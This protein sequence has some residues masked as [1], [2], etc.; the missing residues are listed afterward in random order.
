SITYQYDADGNRIAVTDNHVTTNYAPNNLDQYTAVGGNTYRYDADGN[1]T[2]TSG[3]GGNTAYTYDVENRLIGIATATDTWSYQYD[4]L[5]NR[6]AVTHNGQTT[7]YLVDPT[8]LSSVV[9]EYDGSGNLVAHYTQGLG[10]V[11]RVNG[12]GAA[13]YYDFDSV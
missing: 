13:N 10:L 11:S 6:V 4:V 5:G 3:P 12:T 1:S 7:H 8:G 2:V 9:G